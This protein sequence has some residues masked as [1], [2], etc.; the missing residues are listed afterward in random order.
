MSD[1]SNP[2]RKYDKVKI[3]DPSQLRP[4]DILIFSKTYDDKGDN[5]PANDDKDGHTYLF[6][7]SAGPDG[8]PGTSDD[9]K[10]VG[11]SW[12]NHV[13]QRVGVDLSQS[14]RNGTTNYFSVFRFI[15]KA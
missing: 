6:T 13:P 10:A 2:D 11:A 7:G 9:I 3:D 8:K 4:G 12:S 5:N 15:D 14:G 1:T